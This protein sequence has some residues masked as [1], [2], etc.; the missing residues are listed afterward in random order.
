MVRSDVHPLA[1]VKPVRGEPL[2]TRIKVQLRAAGLAR[3]GDEPLEQPPTVPARASARGGDEVI[4]VKDFPPREKLGVAEA[5][6]GGDS[7]IVSEERE[8]VSA[9]ALLAADA[10]DEFAFDQ[11]RPKFG[12]NG[13]TAKDV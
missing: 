8:L 9:F 13:K 3:P 5:G 12:Q 1:Q 7:S 10:R 11:V 2:H 6:D 4:H